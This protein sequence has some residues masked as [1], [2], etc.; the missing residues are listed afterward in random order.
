MHGIDEESLPA[1]WKLEQH[2]GFPH[3]VV[4]ARPGGGYVSI[5]MTKRIFSAGFCCPHFP[6]HGAATYEGRAWKTRIVGDAVAWLDQ[7][8]A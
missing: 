1:G 6:M 7:Q 3:V 5:N 4:L 2:A 8:M